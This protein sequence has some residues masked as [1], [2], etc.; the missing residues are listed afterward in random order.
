MRRAHYYNTPY[1]TLYIVTY[2]VFF[3]KPKQL[4]LRIM[5]ELSYDISPKLLILQNANIVQTYD[6]SVIHHIFTLKKKQDRS[7][8]RSVLSLMLCHNSSDVMA[9]IVSF[10]LH[11]HNVGIY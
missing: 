8:V 2:K 7:P 11:C 3:V 10:D 1:Y 4:F 9:R 5:A 6:L